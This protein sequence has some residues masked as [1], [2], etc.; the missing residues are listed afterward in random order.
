[1]HTFS[2]FFFSA[3]SLPDFSSIWASLYIGTQ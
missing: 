2:V 1:M 3:D